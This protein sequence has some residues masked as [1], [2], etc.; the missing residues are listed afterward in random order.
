M[1]KINEKVKSGEKV[2]HLNC[3]H[4]FEVENGTIHTWRDFYFDF[5]KYN[6]L[7][8]E[9]TI[10]DKDELKQKILS[11]LHKQ[12]GFCNTIIYQT[13]SKKYDIERML[14]QLNMKDIRYCVV[15]DLQGGSF[16]FDRDYTLDQ[17]RMQAYEWCFADDNYD[18]MLEVKKCPDDALLQYISDLWQIEFRKVRKDKLNLKNANDFAEYAT[19][20]AYFKEVYYDETEENENENN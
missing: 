14:N 8:I 18:L 5:D 11:T 7:I 19:P 9:T 12:L 17:W 6:N 15:S 20:D 1:I 16:G 2:N 10:T 13:Q 4:L 3:P